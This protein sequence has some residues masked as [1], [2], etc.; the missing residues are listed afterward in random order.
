MKKGKLPKINFENCLSRGHKS[1]DRKVGAWWC[2][3]SRNSAHKRAYKNIAGYLG[4]HLNNGSGKTGFMVDYACGDGSFLCQLA[5]RFPSAR[6]VGLDGSEMMLEKA[7]DRLRQSGVNAELCRGRDGFSA[8]GP[9]VRL[10]KTVLPNFSLP[11]GRADVA[12]FLFPNLTCSKKERP[13]YE[14]NGYKNR[15]DTKVAEMLARFREMDPEE[16]VAVMDP[17]ELFDDLMTARVISRNLRQL[18]KKNGSLIRIEYANAPR[19]ELS[20]L[21]NWRSLFTECALDVPIKDCSTEQQFRYLQSRYWRSSVILDVYHQSGD[22]TDQ[23]GGYFCSLL[24][25]I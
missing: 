22:P 14:K 2:G 5:R 16:E 17:G 18:L 10:V 4:D 11:K 24:Q 7:R 25:A 12:V 21:T 9:R 19:E 8:R 6:L 23:E 15:R 3:Q 20:E 1:Y 13:H